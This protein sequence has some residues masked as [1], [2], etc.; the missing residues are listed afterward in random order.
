MIQQIQKNFRGGIMDKTSINE[1]NALLKGE[2]MAID[3]YEKYIQNVNDPNIKGELQ[4]IQQEHKMH[5]IK[6][7]ERIQ[8]L[9][10][11]PVDGVGVMGKGVAL[12][13]KERFP[14]MYKEYVRLCEAKRVRIGEPY[15]Y[16]QLPGH[17]F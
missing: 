13:F 12:G 2:H 16:R 4:K 8:S 7:S 11:R 10:G 15:L 17:G 3:G 6:I 1:L 5:A 9:G 14:D